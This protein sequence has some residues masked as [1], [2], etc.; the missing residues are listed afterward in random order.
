M[1]VVTNFLVGSAV[2]VGGL[3]YLG[4]TAEPVS[5]SIQAANLKACQEQHGEAN[6]KGINKYTESMNCK[7][8]DAYK[9]QLEAE[10][11]AEA[12]AKEEAELK[13]KAERE[14]K[15]AA[16]KASPEGKTK[17]FMEWTATGHCK[18]YTKQ[19][20]KFPNKVDFDWGINRNYWMNFNDNGDSRIMVQFTGEMMNGLGLMVPFKATCKYDYNPETGKSKII[21]FLL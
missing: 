13:A 10:K 9:E 4:A 20:A 12:K 14:A 1:S 6:I 21:E 18:G 3:I 5:E 15:L 7:F 19:S 8:T 2:I 11:I 17:E 16:F